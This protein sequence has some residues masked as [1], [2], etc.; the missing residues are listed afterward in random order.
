MRTELRNSPVASC[1]A[2]ARWRIPR[3]FTST[4]RITT[5]KFAAGHAIY[6]ICVPIA[7]ISARRGKRCGHPRKSLLTHRYNG[8]R[9]GRFM[10]SGYSQFTS[11]VPGFNFQRNRENKGINRPTLQ[12]LHGRTVIEQTGELRALDRYS[13]EYGIR[14]YRWSGPNPRPMIHSFQWCAPELRLIGDA[15][16][17]KQIAL[18]VENRK[19]DSMF[20]RTAEVGFRE[21]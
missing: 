6:L 4:G 13:L 3:H 10:T 17:Q 1:A 19:A 11:Q 14:P 18:Y 7:L 12:P 5:H 21:S 16:K 15:A 9:D 20:A 2:S 8:K